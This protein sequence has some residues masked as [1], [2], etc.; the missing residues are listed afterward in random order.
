MTPVDLIKNLQAYYGVRYT[1]IEQPVVAAWVKS[2]YAKG[3]P[4]HLDAVWEQV[5]TDVSKNF[6]KVPDKALLNDAAEKVRPAKDPNRLP[7]LPA[8]IAPVLTEQ[9]EQEWYE[10]ELDI[11]SIAAKYGRPISDERIKAQVVPAAEVVRPGLTNVRRGEPVK[12]SDLAAKVPLA[13][14][15]KSPQPRLE[16]PGFDFD[17]QD[18]SRGPDVA[19]KSHQNQSSQDQGGRQ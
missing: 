14:S 12:P 1:E 18:G 9:Q 2:A 5:T 4:D 15:P 16:A 7:A 6:G 10:V 19:P 11:R 8:P 13:E 3:G 17:A